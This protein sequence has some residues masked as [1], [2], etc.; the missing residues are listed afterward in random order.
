MKIT[1]VY[2][3]KI[4]KDIRGLKAG[5]GFS[6]FIQ[7]KEKNILFDTGWDGD[8]L[9][10]NMQL[11]DLSPK[12]IDLVVI[13]HSHWDHCGGLSRLLRLNNKLEVYV[14]KSF[15]KHL[16]KE[17]KKRANIFY[18]VQG[19]T[20]ICPGVFTTGEIE[21]SLPIGKTR[22]SI[23]EQSLIISTIKGLVIITGCAHSGIN[24]I[25]N[26]ANK[27]GEIYALLGGFHDFDE[28]NLFKNISLI[29]PT[30]CT[31]N[32]KKILTLFPKNCVEGGVG[33]QLGV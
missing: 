14:P 16:K 4:A 8:V 11:L 31:K 20:K 10:S 6:C 22:I 30:H 7:T 28:Y 18:E 32:K 23:K 29:I 26:S 27:L 9:V 1:I 25:L 21:G 15:S 24:K 17:I 19:L 3:N 33:Y 2:D 12:D 13:S 5:W